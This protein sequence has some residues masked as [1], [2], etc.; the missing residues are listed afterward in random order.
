M[1]VVTFDPTTFVLRYPEFSS[2]DGNLLAMYFQE[3]TIYCSNSSHSIIKD[4]VIR[5]VILNAITAHIA[6]LASLDSDRVGRVASAGEGS[7]NV[8]LAMPAASGSR[9]WYEQTQYGASA[10]LMMSPYRRAIYV[11]PPQGITV[12]VPDPEAM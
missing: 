3:A 11:R 10:W 2:V 4:T 8:S 7:V 9:A 5:A 1:S 12:I 6:K